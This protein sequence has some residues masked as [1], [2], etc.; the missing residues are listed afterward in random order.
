MTQYL[1]E[2]DEDQLQLV[3][4]ALDFFARI[5]TGQISELVNP[6]M[7]PLPDADYKE[8]E[9]L[10]LSLKQQMFPLLPE[11][12]YYSIRSKHIPDTVRQMID[13]Y[14]SIRFHSG[15]EKQKPFNWSSEKRL[16]K[17]IKKI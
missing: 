5:Q 16:P 11:K 13:I 8:V 15:D 1:L 17:I 7:V 14:E 6:Y 12:A 3:S 10:V 9:A 2:L 4:Q